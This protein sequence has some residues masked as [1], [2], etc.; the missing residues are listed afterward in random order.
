[1]NN[2]SPGAQ[3]VMQGMGF[4]GPD[5]YL[6]SW[7]QAVNNWRQQMAANNYSYN[8]YPPAPAAPAAQPPQSLESILANL[9]RL[10]VSP[11]P[12]HRMRDR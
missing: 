8:W 9:K 1:M 7:N 12:M 3:G 2:L 10:S 5:L 4:N 11:H 6:S